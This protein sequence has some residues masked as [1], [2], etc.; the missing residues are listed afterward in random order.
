M[1]SLQTDYFN[2]CVF[3]GW[4]LVAEEV[5]TDFFKKKL[6]QEVNQN[7][8]W[9]WKYTIACV[10]EDSGSNLAMLNANTCVCMLR[11]GLYSILGEI[12]YSHSNQQNHGGT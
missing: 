12:M 3:L 4:N 1:P 8:T 7:V 2:I 9:T 6:S 11:N 10:Q 5:F